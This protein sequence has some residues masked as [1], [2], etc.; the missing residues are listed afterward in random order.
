LLPRCC[1]SLIEQN[2]CYKRVIFA[3]RS[4]RREKRRQVKSQALM[5]HMQ[6][7]AGFVAGLPVSN[8]HRRGFD[9]QR[10]SSTPSLPPSRPH[11][12]CPTTRQQITYHSSNVHS[13]ANSL[14]RMPSAYLTCHNPTKPMCD[15]DATAAASKISFIVQSGTGQKIVSTPNAR[16]GRQPSLAAALGTPVRIDVWIWAGPLGRSPGLSHQFRT[17]T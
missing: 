7:S 9:W 15:A 8:N 12:N 6:T 16:T 2:L 5:E 4:T 14:F 10:F 3:S 17:G 11:D 1:F 13:H